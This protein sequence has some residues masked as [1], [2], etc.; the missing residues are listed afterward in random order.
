MT[1]VAI[2]TA[3]FFKLS[4]RDAD[5]SAFVERVKNVPDYASAG[6][7]A[8]RTTVFVHFEDSV[9][10]V[11]AET[12]V[13]QAVAEHTAAALYATML[14]RMEHVNQLRDSWMNSYFFY[15]G[16]SWD[17]DENGLKNI[18]GTNTSVALLTQ[19]G[20][21]LPANF[22]FRDRNNVNVPADAAYMAGMGLA[23]FKFRSD[24][25]TASWI[26]KYMISQCTTVA[27]VKAYDITVGWP[28]RG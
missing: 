28:D 13:Q 16:H 7:S 15:A 5:F 3:G 2:E 4:D 19:V 17:C 1:T 10:Q 6:E 8:D 18:Q 22:V 11:V 21:T 24:C 23:L 9:T 26:H 25:Y 14:E 27:E 12:A 20:Q